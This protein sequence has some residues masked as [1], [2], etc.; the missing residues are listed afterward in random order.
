MA[1][2]ARGSDEQSSQG[3]SLNHIQLRRAKGQHT[4]DRALKYSDGKM[5]PGLPETEEESGSENIA[6]VLLAG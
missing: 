1:R 6:A 3:T 2:V 4:K 5:G